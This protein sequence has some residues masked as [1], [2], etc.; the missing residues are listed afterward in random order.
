MY[1]SIKKIYDR[2]ESVFEY[3]Q[4]EAQERHQ[5]FKSKEKTKYLSFSQIIFSRI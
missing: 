2:H 5:N 4:Y 1:I 3:A